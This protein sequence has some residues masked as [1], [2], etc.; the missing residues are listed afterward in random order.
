MRMMPG[1]RIHA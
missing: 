1:L